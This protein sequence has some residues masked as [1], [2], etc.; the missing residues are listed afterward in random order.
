M[1]LNFETNH[2]SALVRAQL[3]SSAQFQYFM[4]LQFRMASDGKVLAQIHPTQPQAQFYFNRRKY[5]YIDT[6]C[7]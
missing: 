4:E 5:L 2:H 6:M 7:V 3:N 1:T